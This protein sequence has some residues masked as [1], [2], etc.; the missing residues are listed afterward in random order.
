MKEDNKFKN[1]IY[2]VINKVKNSIIIRAVGIVFIVYLLPLILSLIE[3]KFFDSS[4]DIFLYN[5]CVTISGYVITMVCYLE[6]LR[7]SNAMYTYVR[8]ITM[9]ISVSLSFIF[10]FNT[11]FYFMTIEYWMCLLIITTLFILSI[12]LTI[13]L[14]KEKLSNVD[15]ISNNSDYN[16]AN[17]YDEAIRR[18]MLEKSKNVKEYGDGDCT[19]N[20]ED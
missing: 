8:N 14:V 1:F 7:E 2:G 17:I 15:S 10:F 9:V 3:F 18:E 6:K 20:L 5:F 19:K 13:Y 4:Y 11:K 12:I 16:D